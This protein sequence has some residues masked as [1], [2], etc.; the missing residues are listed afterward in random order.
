M[1]VFYIIAFVIFGL[2]LLATIIALATSGWVV[3]SAT[4]NGVETSYEANL[5]NMY[6][7]GEVLSYSELENGLR[8]YEQSLP[9][10]IGSCNA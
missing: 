8:I 4:V 6:R 10:T 5:V 3:G 9:E 7:N 2:S 1:K